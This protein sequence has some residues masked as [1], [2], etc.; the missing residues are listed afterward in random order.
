MENSVKT[1]AAIA[2]PPGTGAV[3]LIR[4]SGSEAASIVSSIFRGKPA[5]DWKPRQQNFGRIFDSAGDTVDEVLL[6]WFPAPHSFTGEEVVEIA[7]HGGVVVTGK[8]LKAIL[9]AGAESAEPGE[10]SQRAFF[11]G[12]IDLTQAEAIMDLISAQTELAMKAANQQLE[13]RLGRDLEELRQSLIGLIAHLEAYIDF[14]EEDIDPDS[15]DGLIKRCLEITSQIDRWLNTADQGK[16]LRE[17]VRTVICGAPNAGKSSLL[18]LLLGFDRAIV[19]ETAGTTRDTIEEVINL[20]GIPLRLVDTAGIREGGEA[21][22]KEGIQRTFAEIQSAELVIHVVDSSAAKPSDGFIEAAGE[23][24]VLTLL[25]KSDLPLHTDW[26]HTEG[27]ALSCIGDEKIEALKDYLFESLTS[28][29]RFDSS[30]LVSINTRHQ[31]CL[32]RAREAMVAAELNLR[33]GESPE[34]VAMDLRTA[35][36]AIGDVIGKTDIEEILGEIFSSF[37]IGK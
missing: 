31:A 18:N 32:N 8:V 6:T 7:C 14:P 30:S 24:R 10:F 12:K 19:N 25:N 3:S 34:F 1:V 23:V 16:I 26:A 11:N 22:E 27:F 4:V 9:S 5:S 29:N 36:E 20:R 21:I 35:L 17:G 33:S 13:G 2:S 15:N 28:G 37:C